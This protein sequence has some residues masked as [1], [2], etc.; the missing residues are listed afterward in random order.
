MRGSGGAIGQGD[1]WDA[2]CMAWE[3]ATDQL[4]AAGA[5][6]VAGAAS[7]AALSPGMR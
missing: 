3:L 5:E 1:G 4:P 7:A 6:P 2:P